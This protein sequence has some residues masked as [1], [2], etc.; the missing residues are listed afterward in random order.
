MD[1][2]LYKIKPEDFT[3]KGVSAQSNPMELP[4]DEAKAVFDQLAKDVI[5]PKFNQFVDA[6]ADLDITPDA[7]KPISTAVQQAL[8]MTDR[9]RKADGE[10]NGGKSAFRQQLQR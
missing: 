3:G 6:L 4:E 1:A 7:D 9:P 10:R 2:D 5:T 8:D